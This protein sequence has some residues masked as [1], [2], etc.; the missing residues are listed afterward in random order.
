MAGE[1]PFSFCQCLIRCNF[2]CC[3]STFC[4]NED[5]VIMAH[6]LESSCA[7]GCHM[8]PVWLSPHLHRW[9]FS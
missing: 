3:V 8:K 5:L 1:N 2:C 6:A 9:C 4:F 7:P